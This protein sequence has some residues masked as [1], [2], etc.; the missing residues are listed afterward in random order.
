[1]ITINKE[2]VC[3]A[4]YYVEPIE[5]GYK[6][7]NSRSDQEFLLLRDGSE[8]WTL[9]PIIGGFQLHGE[10]CHVVFTFLYAENSDTGRTSCLLYLRDEDIGKLCVDS[11]TLLGR[12]SVPHQKN[13]QAP[14]RWAQKLINQQLRQW[15]EVEAAQLKEQGY[16]CRETGI[17]YSPVEVTIKG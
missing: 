11:I 9:V 15:V 2:G 3:S 8:L 13:S 12:A 5:L 16:K 10:G 7:G 6:E 1:M 17:V 4:T 14:V